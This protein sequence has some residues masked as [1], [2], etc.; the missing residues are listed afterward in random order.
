MLRSK[1]FCHIASR[2]HTLAVW[3]QAGP[4]LSIEPGELLDGHTARQELV[5]IGV[6]LDLDKPRRRIDPL[7]GRPGPQ[8]CFDDAAGRRGHRSDRAFL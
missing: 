1:G 2:P 4:N 7:A 8:H 6:E 5:V 3:S